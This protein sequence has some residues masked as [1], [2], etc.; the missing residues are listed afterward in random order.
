MPVEAMMG[1]TLTVDGEDVIAAVLVMNEPAVIPAPVLSVTGNVTVTDLPRPSDC[2]PARAGGV[3]V[4]P[5]AGLTVTGPLK[6]T[7]VGR[8]S[9][10]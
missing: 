8:V 7:L 2:P 10:R 6:V 3:P 9:L 4:D 1:C 5:P